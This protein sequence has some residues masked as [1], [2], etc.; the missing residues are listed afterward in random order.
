M[1]I[2]NNK[3]NTNNHIF[4]NKHIINLDARESKALMFRLEVLGD[5][6]MEQSVNINLFLPFIKAY[7]LA[8]KREDST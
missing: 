3:F 5:K 2:T 7:D 6:G 4:Y 8:N 1:Y